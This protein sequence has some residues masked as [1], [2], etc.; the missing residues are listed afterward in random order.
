MQSVQLNV[1]GL[2][3]APSDFAGLPPGSLDEAINVESRHKNILE[4]RRGFDALVST[5]LVGDSWARLFNFPVLGTDKVIGLT[6]NGSL[7]YYNGSGVTLLSGFSTGIVAPDDL[8]KNRFIRGGQ[9]MYL[10]EQ[11]GVLSLSSGSGSSVLKAGV[12]RGLDLSAASNAASSGFLTANIVITTVG[13]VANTSAVITKIGDSTGVEVGQYVSGIGIPAGATV[14]SVANESIAVVSPATTTVGGTTIS[15]VANPSATAGQLVSGVGIQDGTKVVSQSGGGPYVVTISIAA[16]Q[17][18]TPNITLS[19]PFSVTLSASA[20]ITTAGTPVIFY[21]GSQVAYRMLFGRVETDI[22]G[23]TTTRYGAPSAIAIATNTL[24]HTTNTTVIGTLPKNA[25]T[26]IT[27]VQLYRSQQTESS[28]IVP[29]DQMQLVYERELVAGDFTARQIT[30]TDAAPDSTMGIPLYTGSDREG[31]LK[32]NLPPPTCWDMTVFRNIG[33][34]ANATQPSTLDLTLTAV[35]AASGLQVDD[36]ITIVSGS[37]TGTYTGKSSESLASHQFKIFSSGTAAQNISDTLNS[38]IRVIN[39]D[40]TL[41]VHAILTSTSTDLPGQFTLEADSPYG[42][43]T[44]TVSAHATA[45]SPT[46]TNLTSEINGYPNGVFVSKDGEIES[47]PGAN[48]L[49]VGDSSSGILRI[50]SLRDYVVVLK[51]DGIYK[52]LGNTS[53]S[54]SSISFDLTTKLIG[55]DTAVQLNSGVWMLSNQGVVSVDDAGVNAKSPPIDNLINELLGSTLNGLNF[56]SFGVGYESDRKYVL[57]VPVNND[58]EVTTTQFVFNY[59]TN[60]WTTWNRALTTA[61]IHSNEGKMYIGR[62]DGTLNGISKERRAG[63]FRDFSDESIAVVIDTVVSETEVILAD[64][65]G[66]EVGDILFQDNGTLS[67][68]LTVNDTPN[69]ITLQFPNDWSTGAITILK[70]IDCSVSFKQVFGDNPAFERQFPEGIALFK[71]ARFNEATLRL[72]TDFS[73]SQEEVTLHSTLLN[74]WGLFSWGSGQWG[75]SQAPSGIRFL[76]PQN[77]QL[78]SYI[79]PTLKIKEAWS[80][81]K[82]QG[83]SISWSP[84][85]QELGK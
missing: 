48:L 39:Y 41:P 40:Q 81:W 84:V 70:A 7:Y 79:I 5:E 57:S 54:L 36:V 52:I 51:T 1:S 20:T 45:F 23:N 64:A 21:S 29:L 77:K 17:A 44:A 33:L 32:A 73:Q 74:G 8:A 61:F 82:F 55:P 42:T 50:I 38:L 34:F 46:L 12:P 3:T 43:F 72:F 63:T 83:M 24:G 27:F 66:V 69:A 59:V 60:S 80:S 6:A 22:N 19:T 16:Y 10:T 2:Y 15:F 28:A 58:S 75:G 65:N 78:A 30:V 53:S 37:I 4:S 85:S 62:A 25:S 18:G 35:G 71:E 56:V 26:S 47:V 67:P 31:I 76:V 13:D 9:N 49:L 14:L 11:T 68:I